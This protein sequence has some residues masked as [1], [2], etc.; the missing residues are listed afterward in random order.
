MI[1]T[2]RSAS[3]AGAKNRAWLLIL[4]HVCLG[5]GAAFWAAGGSWPDLAEMIFFALVCAQAAVL[6]V[7]ARHERLSASGPG[8][9]LCAGTIF[10]F[11]LVAFN[12]RLDF[13]SWVYAAYEF[14][15]LLSLFVVLTPASI[16]WTALVSRR[17][18][19]R[20]ESSR[21]VFQET[22]GVQFSMRQILA[23]VL[24]LAVLL[25]AARLAVQQL[26]DAYAYV[27]TLLLFGVSSAALTLVACWLELTQGWTLPR[28]LVASVLVLLIVLG[29]PAVFRLLG[30][31]VRAEDVFL[32]VTMLGIQAI[33]AAA[34]LE[35]AGFLGYRLVEQ[36][37]TASP[38]GATAPHEAVRSESIVS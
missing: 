8:L 2:A 29:P 17:A 24:L 11:V 6:G 30:V 1:A 36:T 5:A 9:V 28:V 38:D 14:T 33:P 3:T 16:V 19:L 13:G 25:T 4:V 32:W 23:A 27:F 37:A 34:S 7:L 31:A 10:L 20:R 26:G 18:V 21:R 15:L 35:L 12:T 22:G